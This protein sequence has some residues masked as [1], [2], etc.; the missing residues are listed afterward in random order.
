MSLPRPDMLNSGMLSI[1]CYERIHALWDALADFDAA[2]ADDAIRSLMDGLCLLVNAQNANWVGAVRM[3]DILPGDPVHGWRV[4][5]VHHLHSTIALLNATNEQVNNLDRGIVDESTLRNVALAGS[6]RVNRIEDL[7]PGW[8]DSDYCKRYF[9]AVGRADAIWAGMPI[10]NDSEFYFGIFRDASQPRFT[11]QERDLIGYALRGLKWLCRR[12]MLNLGLIV[13]S[14]PLTP[15]EREVLSGLLTGQSE[16]QIAA[17]RKQS[18]HTTH[19]CI[20]SIYR[21]YGV[22]N[23]AAL[24]AIWLGRAS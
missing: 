22:R 11:P 16:K 17:T 21:K 13:A 12:Q 9:K 20:I 14:A 8:L 24:M 2:H 10:N 15:M 3:P 7:V 18:P 6:F 5:W 19:D 23:R 4:H 1:D